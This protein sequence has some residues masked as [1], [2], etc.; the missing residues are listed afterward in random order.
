MGLLYLF[1][2]GG[3]GELSTEGGQP[4]QLLSAVADKATPQRLSAA[5]DNLAVENLLL[6]LPLPRHPL[7]LQHQSLD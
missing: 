2:W 3:K 6:Y 5:A 7:K 4:P 1:C